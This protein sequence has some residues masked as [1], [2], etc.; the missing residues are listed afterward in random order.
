MNLYVSSLKHGE[1]VSYSVLPGRVAWVQIARGSLTFGDRELTAGDGI[2]L[3]EPDI[4]TLAG[5]SETAELLL[6]DLAV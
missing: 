6:F 3:Q 1:T 2:A 5:T 4:L